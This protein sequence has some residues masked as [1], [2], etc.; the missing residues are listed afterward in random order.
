[1]AEPTLPAHIRAGA[2]AQDRC[3]LVF[4]A[5]DGE[6]PATLGGLVSDA[7]KVALLKKAVLLVLPSRREGFP[8][9]IAEAAA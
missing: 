8:R 9:V 1:M 7:E 6:R 5:A 2:A 4:A 3:P